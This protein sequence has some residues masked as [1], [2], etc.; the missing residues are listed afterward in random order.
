MPRKQ[1]GHT[2]TQDATSQIW[3]CALPTWNPVSFKI[4]RQLE[5]RYVNNLNSQIEPMVWVPDLKS[6]DLKL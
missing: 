2:T 4:Q 1:D 5:L 3:N 6:G